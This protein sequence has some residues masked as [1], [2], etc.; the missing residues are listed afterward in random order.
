[1]YICTQ[2]TW[3]AQ[4][5]V[6][7]RLCTWKILIN[8]A[9]QLWSGEQLCASVIWEKNSHRRPTSSPRMRTGVLT[10]TAVASLP[11]TLFSQDCLFMLPAA[12]T[13]LPWQPDV[14]PSG[15]AL[16]WMGQRT[17]RQ[18]F[19]AHSELILLLALKMLLPV[20]PQRDNK[21]SNHKLLSNAFP[22]W[23]EEISGCP[24]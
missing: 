19:W 21:E 4:D 7:K 14:W 3:G 17:V 11:S 12:K 23:T 24:M 18:G 2:R 20:W 1:M 5:R 8:T 13:L 9:N 22:E 10:T 6:S 15:M 16:N